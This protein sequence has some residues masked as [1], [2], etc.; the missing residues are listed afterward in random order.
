MPAFSPFMSTK[1]S[2][3]DMVKENGDDEYS[4]DE[5]DQDIIT[6]IQKDDYGTLRE[7]LT[8]KFTN[9]E[10][11]EERGNT[12]LRSA[13]VHRDFDLSKMVIDILGDHIDYYRRWDDHNEI[14]DCNMLSYACACKDLYTF[15]YILNQVDLMK[16]VDRTLMVFIVDRHPRMLKSIIDKYDK[17]GVPFLKENHSNY[18]TNKLTV[19]LYRGLHWLDVHGNSETRDELEQ[20]GKLLNP[21]LDMDIVRD[22]AKYGND[23]YKEDVKMQSCGQIELYDDFFD[24]I[25]DSYVKIY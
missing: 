2:S 19:E 14:G 6:T 25:F 8:Y 15:L 20:I 9:E 11:L 7:M 1:S 18:N 21:L 23:F 24:K 17:C 16:I 4:F 13:I 3:W 22:V 10:I 12:M 5:F